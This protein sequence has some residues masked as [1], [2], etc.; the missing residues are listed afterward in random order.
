MLASAIHELS[1]RAPRPMVKVSCAAI[2]ATFIESELLGRKRAR[3]GVVPRQVGRFEMSH[4]STLFL[5]EEGELPLEVQVKSLRALQE[6]GVE[7]LGQLQIHFCR[8]ANHG[9]H[10]PRS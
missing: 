2:P 4:G 10:E 1:L 6:K 8:R 7:R 5:E 3:T 9:R